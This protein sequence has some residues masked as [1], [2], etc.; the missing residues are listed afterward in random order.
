MEKIFFFAFIKGM[1]GYKSQNTTTIV[2]SSFNIGLSMY[3]YK[4]YSA[5]QLILSKVHFFSHGRL[6]A[7]A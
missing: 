7:K 1:Q 3:I 2:I 4:N 6:I 5:V